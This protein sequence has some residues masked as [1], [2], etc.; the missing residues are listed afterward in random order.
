MIVVLM[1]IH[2]K[3]KKKLFVDVIKFGGKV[4]EFRDCKK[5]ISHSRE[6]AKFSF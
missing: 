5:L 4:T 6:V 1:I 3:V 2:Y